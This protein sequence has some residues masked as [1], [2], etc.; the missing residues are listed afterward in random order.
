MELFLQ[1]IPF[2]VLVVAV[3]IIVISCIAY[4]FLPFAVIGMKR[5]L[6]NQSAGIKRRLDEQ[7]AL[8]EV[9]VEAMESDYEEPEADEMPENS[10]HLE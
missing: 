8:L 9:L 3:P 4:I 7:T 1:S 10:A 6:D 5:R 2:A